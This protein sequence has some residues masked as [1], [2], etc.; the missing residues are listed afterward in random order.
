M[1]SFMSFLLIFSFTLSAPYSKAFA[2]ENSTNAVV[3]IEASAGADCFK[4][5]DPQDMKN[6]GNILYLREETAN[7]LFPAVD[8]RSFEAKRKEIELKFSG[9]KRDAALALLVFSEKEASSRVIRKA[10]NKVLKRKDSTLSHE[11]KE[12]LSSFIESAK[13][14]G[15]SNIEETINLRITS[16]SPMAEELLSQKGARITD[17]GEWNFTPEFDFEAARMNPETKNALRSFF[18]DEVEELSYE[19]RG[20]AVMGNRVVRSVPDPSQKR[21]QQPTRWVWVS[22]DL[23]MHIRKLLEIEDRLIKKAEEYARLS[24]KNSHW[25]TLTGAALDTPAY[26]DVSLLSL[27]KSALGPFFS[28]KGAVK[29]ELKKPGMSEEWKNSLNEQDRLYGEIGEIS[30]ELHMHGAPLETI[31][32]VIQQISQLSKKSDADMQMGLKGMKRALTAV[33]LAPLL[34]VALPEVA[35]GFAAAGA[36]GTTTGVIVATAGA[37]LTVVS[38]VTPVAIATRNIMKAIQSGDGALCS[39]VKHG[40]I[41]PV[42]MSETLRWA[43]LGPI[44][45]TLRPALGG[46]DKVVGLTLLGPNA[47][48]Y[49]A[50]VPLSFLVGSTILNQANATLDAHQAVNNISEALDQARSSGN[51][52]HVLVL[53]EMLKNARESRWIIVLNLARTSVGVLTAINEKS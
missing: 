30:I 12:S 18:P 49:A 35:A 52:A 21:G 4:S 27:M 15:E 16:L 45:K 50:I 32:N 48:K 8:K 14:N 29:K 1:H 44:V 7:L 19:S 39:I 17:E 5:L 53:E 43:A 28:F 51:E 11:D 10:V 24:K 20:Y 33:V 22:S 38:L 6:L 31:K 23:D 13:K 41:V 40:A 34:P 47:R 25:L 36:A 26:G 2:E 3:K 9:E 37:S 46:L 42:E